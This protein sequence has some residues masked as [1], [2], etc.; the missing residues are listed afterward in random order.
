M[1]QIKFTFKT[2][3]ETGVK[4][5][6]LTLEVPLYTMDSII[7]AINSESE[8]APKVHEL[9]VEAV[10]S[11]IID[12]A[13][14]QVNADGFTALDT[15]V[16]SLEAIASIPPATRKSN[17]IPKEDW[18]AFFAAYKEH[19]P[20]LLQL[21]AVKVQRQLAAMQAKL[22][23]IEYR[24]DLLAKVQTYLA[25]FADSEVAADHARVI[26]DLLG[27]C[28]QYLQADNEAAFG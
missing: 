2:N 25:V 13:K 11:L 26:A 10:N 12:Q 24:K 19:A 20:E 15:S 18:T 23:T 27:R 1:A 22:K 7:D 17:A 6:A 14:Q 16:L 8:L 3:K 4:R 21:P 28:D 9:I 5:D